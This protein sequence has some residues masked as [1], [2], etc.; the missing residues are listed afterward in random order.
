MYGRGEKE[1]FIFLGD[2]FFLVR[3]IVWEIN[4]L[5]SLFVVIKRFYLNVRRFF[6]FLLKDLGFKLRSMK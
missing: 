2:K 4:L 1:F 6:L 3:G 5:I